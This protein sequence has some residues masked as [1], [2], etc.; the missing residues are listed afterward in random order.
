MYTGSSNPVRFSVFSLHRHLPL[1]AQEGQQAQTAAGSHRC[2]VQQKAQRAKAE[3]QKDAEELG[4]S[5]QT[6]LN[7][8]VISI[9]SPRDGSPSCNWK[10]TKSA[11]NS[12]SSSG[13]AASAT[14]D[15]PDNDFKEEHYRRMLCQRAFRFGI[16]GWKT[17]RGACTS[18]GP[19]D[20]N[21]SASTGGTY[22]VRWTK[23]AVDDDVSWETWRYATWKASRNIIWEFVD[24]T[25]SGEYH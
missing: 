5:L 9:I 13:C 21:R 8:D 11:S 24:P 14:P 25:S 15:L 3:A 16:P 18:C 17:D 20:E 10:R 4:H 7:E 23:V 1:K 12:S 6:V 22:D 2:T 19:P